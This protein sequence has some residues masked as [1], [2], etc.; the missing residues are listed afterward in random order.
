MF[1]L[2]FNNVHIMT[3]SLLPNDKDGEDGNNCCFLTWT[4]IKQLKRCLDPNVKGHISDYSKV[5]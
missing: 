2:S 4:C 5:R 3:N 1:S